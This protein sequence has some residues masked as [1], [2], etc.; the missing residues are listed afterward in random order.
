MISVLIYQLKTT[1]K[2]KHL[3]L[4]LSKKIKIDENQVEVTENHNN[5]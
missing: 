2:R 1:H 3:I 4:L 5:L